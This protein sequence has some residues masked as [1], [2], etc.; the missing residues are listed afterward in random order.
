MFVV[1]IF[2]EENAQEV[3]VKTTQAGALESWLKPKDQ[4]DLFNEFKK[5]L[6]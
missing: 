5:L 4:I 2:R 1:F 6:L 3:G